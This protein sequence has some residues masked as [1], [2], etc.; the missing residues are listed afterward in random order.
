MVTGLPISSGEAVVGFLFL[1]GERSSFVVSLPLEGSYNSYGA[2]D[3]EGP[4]EIRVFT[5]RYIQEHLVECQDWK[6]E[7]G[8]KIPENLLL[9]DIIGYAE[10]ASARTDEFL[11]LDLGEISERG[12]VTLCLIHQFVY[13]LAQEEIDLPEEYRP[14][15][16]SDSPLC[17]YLRGTQF[18]WEEKVLAQLEKENPEHART[19]RK[20]IGEET[21]YLKS[22][23]KEET[24]VLDSALHSL[25]K[26]DDYLRLLRREWRPQGIGKGS[27]DTSYWKH[28][29]LLGESL[30]FASKRY[31]SDCDSD[32]CE[33]VEE[34]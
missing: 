28:L 29:K 8:H 2:L 3:F 1:Q 17:F 34:A 22:L 16:D 32:W 14:H 24:Q 20:R 7:F 5:E 18:F 19:I 33:H 15:F 23:P 25:F 6:T 30:K 11:S 13:N 10:R 21:G 4:Q 12:K 31:C 9:K 26:F 27:Q